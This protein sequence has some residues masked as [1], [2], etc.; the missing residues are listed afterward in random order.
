MGG[1]ILQSADEV[2]VELEDEY[3]VVTDGQG[4]AGPPGVGYVAVFGASGKPLDG[5]VL[6][7]HVFAD[8]ILFPA[9]LGTSRA[10]AV[11]AAAADA[12][13][14]LRKNGVEFGTVT[15]ASGASVG[16]F[17]AASAVTF[18]IGDVATVAC[19]N[20]QDVSLMSPSITLRGSRA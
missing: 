13:F 18:E 2:I 11:A 4:A 9:D 16:T 17:A 10:V 7:P 1:V 20:P 14:S 12:E 5:E 3:V 19:P 8:E 6:I 15:F